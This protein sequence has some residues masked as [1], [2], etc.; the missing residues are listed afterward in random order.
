MENSI[1]Y[2]LGSFVYKGMPFELTN[3]PVTF[4]NMMNE[5]FRDIIDLGVV[6]YLDNILI[7]S[8]N[9][10]DHV[11]LV[12]RVLERLQEH[13]LAITPDKCEWH[14]STDN[15]L[16]YVFSLKGVEM[17]QDKIRTIVEWEAPDSVK[18]VQSFLGF[19]NFYR[20]FIV[21]YSKLTRPLTD[22]TKKS[23]KFFWSDECGCAFEELKQ[24][25]TSAPILRHYDPALPCIIKCDA[26]DFAIGAVFSLE[27]EG[28]LH[29]VAFLSHKRNKHEINYEIHDMELLAITAA[30]KECHRY[31]SSARHKISV[32]TDHRGLE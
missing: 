32:Q 25:F 3:A 22:L 16:G 7:Y 17:D 26:S 9:D 28:R 1:L 29:P 23:K 12:K 11:A 18:G 19:A 21:G 27:F 6:I 4:Q 31:L 8:E 15:F 13:Q 10:Q 14:R 30:F 2:A 20:R 5:I 24:R